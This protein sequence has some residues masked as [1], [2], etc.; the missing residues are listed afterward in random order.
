M[1][2]MKHRSPSLFR[3]LTETEPSKFRKMNMKKHH[4][5]LFDFVAEE[6]WCVRLG[7]PPTLM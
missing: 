1:A 3:H 5:L 7:V 4:D 6:K 2:G